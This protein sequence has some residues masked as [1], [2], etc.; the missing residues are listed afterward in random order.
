MYYSL[1]SNEFH[2]NPR[3]FPDKYKFTKMDQDLEKE[4]LAHTQRLAFMRMKFFRIYD[5]DPYF[6]KDEQSNNIEKCTFLLL[7]SVVNM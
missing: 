3:I 6:L 7:F 4:T 1:N 5:M 2:I